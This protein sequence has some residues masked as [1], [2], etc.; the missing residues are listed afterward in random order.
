MKRVNFQYLSPNPDP[1]IKFYEIKTVLIDEI[2]LKRLVN[3]KGIAY[4]KDSDS[5]LSP[6]LDG[7]YTWKQLKKYLGK[8]G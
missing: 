8:Y 2:T 3:V 6:F 7:Q 1:S 5:S 4:I